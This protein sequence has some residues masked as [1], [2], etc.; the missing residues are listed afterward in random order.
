MAVN[1][2]VEPFS[3]G[4]RSWL[5]SN[6]IC[7]CIKCTSCL[8]IAKPRPVPPNWRVTEASPCEKDSNSFLRSV[9]LSPMPLSCTLKCN[10]HCPISSCSILARTMISPSGVNLMALE[11]RLVKICLK[12]RASPTTCFGTLSA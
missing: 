8:E 4:A 9:P 5:S 6:P 11:I 2:K 3:V 1:Q 7:P 12:R 10:R